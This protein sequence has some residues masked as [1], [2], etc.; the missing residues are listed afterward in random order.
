VILP[1]VGELTEQSYRLAI[2]ELVERDSS[3]AGVVT[4]WGNP[5]FWTHPPGFPGI[6]LAIL[7]QQVS[8]ESAQGTFRKLENAISTITPDAFLTLNADTLREIGFSRQKASYAQKIAEDIVAA[9]ID[10]KALQ[11][12]GDTEAR[13]R[14]MQ[15]RG[16]GKWTA[17][18]YLLFSLRRSDVWPSG[19]L[20]LEKT[21]SELRGLPSKLKTEEVDR[22]AAA[23]KPLRAVAARILWC[24][25]LNQR[26]RFHSA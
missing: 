12:I 16:V 14:L 25:Y 19:D 15:I 7:A 13:T 2:S 1:Q 17:D 3:L 21:V 6:T 9:K 4:K 23:W 11:G 26:G 8:L 18:T 5:P 22:I 20:A 24:Q 10:F